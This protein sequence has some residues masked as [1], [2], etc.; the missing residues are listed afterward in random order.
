M[1]LNRCVRDSFA[2]VLF[3]MVTAGICSA[4]TDVTHLAES[5]LNAL[6]EVI[7]APDGKGYL[8]INADGKK[9]LHV[10]GS[11]YQMGY[12]HG[13]LCAEGV[14]AMASYEFWSGLFIHLLELEVDPDDV[15]K[16]LF[17]DKGVN[18]LVDK[19]YEII[20]P[21]MGDIPEEFILEMQ[22]IVD[23][24]ND[25]GYTEVEFKHVVMNNMAFDAILAKMF[26]IITPI[27]PFAKNLTAPHCCNA[28]VAMGQATADGGTLMG[29]D[30]MF[31]NGVYYKHGLLIEYVPD[32]GNR[33]VSVMAPSFV[34]TAAGMN[35]KGIGIGIDVVL[36]FDTT[37]DK[38]GMGG[39]MLARYVLQNAHELQEGINILRSKELGV[40]WLFPIGDGIGRE[41]GGAVVEVSAQKS[42]VRKMNYTQPAWALRMGIPDQMENESDMI[43]VTNH[44]IMP[45]MYLTL[46]NAFEDSTYRYDILAALC[47]EAYGTID[48]DS[49]R[50]LIDFLHPPNYDYYGSDPDQPVESSVSFYDLSNLKLW[51]LYGLYSDPWVSFDLN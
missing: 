46:S 21:S 32:H 11:P 30:F 10:E 29:R 25:A 51:S 2:V 47:M 5:S 18:F 15:Y 9:L 12:Q 7:Y 38:L 45:A 8:G 49:G 13:Y 14:A 28:F 20:E 42:R 50:T 39:L 31:P 36:S 1:K 24:A 48:T 19:L 17:G 35:D 27:L 43:V 4:E 44:Y 37:V 6:T 16:L 33:F 3:L 40:S 23:G 41:R 34:G 22:G 26:K